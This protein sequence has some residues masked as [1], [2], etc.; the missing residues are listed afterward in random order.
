MNAVNY[1]ETFGFGYQDSLVF[2]SDIVETL[3]SKNCKM[4]FSFEKGFDYVSG[5]LGM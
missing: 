5:L 1:R 3:E 2:S 4:L